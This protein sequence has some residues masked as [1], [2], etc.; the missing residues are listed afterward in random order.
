MAAV[1][2]PSGKSLLGKLAGAA[3]Q[4]AA[5][6]RQRPSRTAAFISDHLLTACAL[7]AGV[8]DAFLHSRGWGLGS[9]VPALLI[10]DFKIRG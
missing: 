4:R 8:A 6:R 10:L 9:L 5:V 3:A 7:G 2:V 1:S